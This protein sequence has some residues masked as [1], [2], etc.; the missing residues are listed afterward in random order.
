MIQF[1]CLAMLCL[2]YAGCAEQHA[3]PT[4]VEPTDEDFFEG[5][6][7]V[8]INETSIGFGDT[9]E[10]SGV[11]LK[12]NSFSDIF[13]GATI[14]ALRIDDKPTQE[15]IRFLLAPNAGKR[16]PTF[17][18][19]QRLTPGSHYLVRGKLLNARINGV[20]NACS[21]RAEGVEVIGTSPL[22]IADF[23]NREA[24]FDGLA[25]SEGTFTI[26][27]ET[28]MLDAVDAWP[29][30]VD[31]KQVAVHG[32]VRNDDRGIWFERPTWK[33][34]R[35]EDLVDQVVVFDGVIGSMNGECWFEYRG[36]RLVLISASGPVLRFQP[37]DQKRPT[38]VTGRLALQD[39]AT[40]PDRWQADRALVP[41][42]VVR[43]PKVEFVGPEPSWE[44][45]YGQLYP[46]H[47]RTM[48]GVPMLLA[49]PGFRRSY[50]GTESKAML[51]VERNSE[52]I[53]NVLHEISS[54][55]C[56]E[57]ARRMADESIDQAL[58]LVYAAMLANVNDERGRTFLLKA[59]ENHGREIDA[60]ALYC[61]G[62]FPYLAAAGDHEADIAW[63]KKPLV[64]LMRNEKKVTA[65]GLVLDQLG[66]VPVA[67]A[68]VLCSTIPSVMRQIGSDDCRRA[69]QN[70]VA[71]RAIG[72]NQ[73]A[74][75]LCRWSPPLSPDELVQLD[76]LV[77]DHSVHR[78]VLRLLL[79]HKAPGV[80]D[81]FQKDLKE[82]FVYM[83][84]RD[85]LS[86]EIVE[87]LQARLD[88]FSGHAKDHAQMLIALGQDDPV[89]ELL[90]MLRDPGWQDKNLVFFELARLGDLR[91]VVPV[92]SFL[93][94]APKDAVK[95]DRALSDTNTVIHALQAIAHTGSAEAIRELIE[96]LPV[97]L[98]RFGGYIKRQGWQ[99]VVAAHLIE[100]TGESFGTDVE[101]WRA[102]QRAHPDHRV[103]RELANPG[104]HFRT[105]P[106]ANIDF[107]Q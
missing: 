33:L 15:E 106:G 104:G 61:L 102:W 36:E 69:L 74:E 51:F 17:V 12:H 107:G 72:G 84:F 25:T 31:G 55:H 1:R 39:R 98:G 43:D 30:E 96:L 14:R 18:D 28:A 2:V 70:F 29:K 105:G 27:D 46:S 32:I 85:Q 77:D 10:V 92:A 48:N 7:S 4:H 103:P 6:G 23:V 40:A 13:S 94:D 81:R 44:E 95:D 75:E 19:L 64:E 91:A 88:R 67:S 62:V 53:R 37:R 52:V 56:D 5:Q 22:R 87:Q 89:A 59:S 26:G 45:K 16:S 80:V 24:S 42:Y 54:E 76:K 97:D 41:T 35:L 100:L 90:K 73:A 38:R 11:C 20:N 86:P 65:Q 68:S 49:E 47:H 101:K 58:Q 79:W 9:V 34:Y 57:L 66:K 82:S 3:Q 63:A 93:R 83:D 71:S 50:M 8:V 99:R 60:N 21:L 78:M